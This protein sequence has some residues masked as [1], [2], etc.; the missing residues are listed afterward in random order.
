MPKAVIK[1]PRLIYISWLRGKEDSAKTT[2][3]DRFRQTLTVDTESQRQQFPEPRSTG[4]AIHGDMLNDEVQE[5]ITDLVSVLTD[6][7]LLANM[8]NPPET[9]PAELALFIRA[10]ASDTADRQRVW[11]APVA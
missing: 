8:K 2:W 1:D 9:D 3:V 5:Q 7:Y 4:D 10:K 11:L 6:P